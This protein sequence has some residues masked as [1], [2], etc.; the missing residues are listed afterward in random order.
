L[1]SHD[2]FGQYG[3]ITKVVVNKR[4]PA[5]G[6]HTHSSSPSTSN[7]G[8]Y[9]TFSKKDDAARA[10]EAVDGTNYEGKIKDTYI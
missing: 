5:S 4:T 1:R 6:P 2:Y 8:V 3:K 9:I 7:T 10:I